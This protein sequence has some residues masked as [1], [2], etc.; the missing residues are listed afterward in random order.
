MTLWF[1]LFFE[2]Y[3]FVSRLEEQGEKR[4]EE[5]EEFVSFFD[6]NKFLIEKGSVQSYANIQEFDPRWMF[7]SKW[8]GLAF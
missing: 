8:Y 6:K 3:G 1:L 7:L 5:Q 4:D 2:F